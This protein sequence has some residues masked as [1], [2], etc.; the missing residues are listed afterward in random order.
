MVKMDKIKKKHKIANKEKNM[1]VLHFTK[2]YLQKPQ[3]VGGI[4]VENKWLLEKVK[5][6]RNY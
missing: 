1:V 2:L 4:V 6:L 3:V 5:I